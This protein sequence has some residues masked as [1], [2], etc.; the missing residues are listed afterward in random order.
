MNNPS[1]KKTTSLF[2]FKRTKYT[3]WQLKTLCKELGLTDSKI[4]R[5]NYKKHGLPAHPERIYDEWIS[6]HDFFDSPEFITYQEMKNLIAERQFKNAKE[7]KRFVYDQKNETLP[8]DPQTAY[9]EEWE[10]WYVFLGKPEPFKPEF[11]RSEER[12]VG[13]E[14]RTR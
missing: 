12:R 2:E 6:Y 5:D 7:Y 1:P 14:C 13:K 3:Y 10:N 8:L 4:Y 11:I 9:T